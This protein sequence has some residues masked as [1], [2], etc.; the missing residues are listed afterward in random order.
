MV[1]SRVG[2]ACGGDKRKIAQAV[3]RSMAGLFGHAKVLETI[4]LSGSALVKEVIVAGK[5]YAL[6]TRPDQRAPS[7]PE[8]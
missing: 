6:P 8:S 7:R 4:S 2:A 3:I 1:S 5:G